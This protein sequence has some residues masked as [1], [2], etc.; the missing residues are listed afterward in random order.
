MLLYGHQGGGG[1]DNVLDE[2]STWTTELAAAVCEKKKGTLGL[3]A[4][5]GVL[6]SP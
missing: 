4:G 5:H 6:M 3:T 2:Y 1:C